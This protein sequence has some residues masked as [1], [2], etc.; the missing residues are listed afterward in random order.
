VE[1]VG[2]AAL[3]NQWQQY[4]ELGGLQNNELPEGRPSVPYPK[5]LE[6]L[7]EDMPA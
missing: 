1:F 3:H 5:A 7:D 6:V 2:G 4:N